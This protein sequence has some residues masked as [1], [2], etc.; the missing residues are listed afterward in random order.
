[1]SLRTRIL[2]AVSTAAISTTTETMAVLSSRTTSVCRDKTMSHFLKQS[3]ETGMRPI[4][5]AAEGYKAYLGL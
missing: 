5:Q 2:I 4:V 3:V 1:M